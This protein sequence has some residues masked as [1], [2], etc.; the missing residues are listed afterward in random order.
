M[1]NYPSFL[2]WWMEEDDIDY[3]EFLWLDAKR[4][5][6]AI[7]DAAQWASENLLDV[8][9]AEYRNAEPLTVSLPLKGVILA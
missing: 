2:F 1:V 3:S 6:T 9:P 5:F 4:V 8:V 7:L